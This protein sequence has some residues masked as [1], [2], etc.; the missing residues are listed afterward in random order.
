[1]SEEASEKE[2]PENEKR[3]GEG[4][5]GPGRPKGVPN[6]L[7]Q[8]AREALQL[9]FEGLGGV[10]RLI[11]WARADD[12]LGDFYKLYA[13]LIPVEVT[14]KDGKDLV[15]EADMDLMAQARLIIFALQKAAQPQQP[16]TH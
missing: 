12:N 8:S 3:I 5:P 15:P 2:T 7:T 14:G 4:K 13:R 6:K 1:M 11:E 10:E 9:A 16:T